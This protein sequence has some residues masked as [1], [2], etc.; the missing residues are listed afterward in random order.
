MVTGNVIMSCQNLNFTFPHNG[1]SKTLTN[2]F[3]MVNMALNKHLEVFWVSFE[4]QG[5]EVEEEEKHN[6]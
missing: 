5:V 1:P 4:K 2:H 3:E 6:Q